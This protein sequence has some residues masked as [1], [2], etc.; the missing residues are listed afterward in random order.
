M[1]KVTALNKHPLPGHSRE[2]IQTHSPQ[3]SLE[4]LSS[5]EVFSAWKRTDEEQTVEELYL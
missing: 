5:Q 3:E 1:T 4:P 2:D